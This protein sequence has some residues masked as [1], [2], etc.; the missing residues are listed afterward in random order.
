MYQA[1]EIY[2]RLARS[3]MG[4]AES[5]SAA[6]RGAD[7]AIY[8]H[9]ADPNSSPSMRPPPDQRAALQRKMSSFLEE[10]I[11]HKLTERGEAAVTLRASGDGRDAADN[12]SAEETPTKLRYAAS[13]MQGW[14]SH[15]ED[16]HCLDPPLARN[17]QQ[18]ELLKDHH[19]F[20]VFDGHGGEFASRF[21][22][23]HFVGTL[24]RQREW[25]TY[26]QLA[27]GGGSGHPS[28]LT[29]QSLAR[30]DSVTGLALL[31][32]ALTSAFLDLD[33]QLMEAQRSVRLGQLSKLETLVYS[34][35]GNVEHDVFQRGT[36][37]HNGLLNFDRTLPGRMPAQVPLE[38]SGST[39][40][41]VLVTPSHIVC[42]NAG[43]SRAFLSKR[44]NN[45]GAGTDGVLPLSFD[46]KPTNDCEVSRVER[47]GGFV[48]AG[49]VDGDL[50]VSRSFGDFGYKNCRERDDASSSGSSHG[51]SSPESRQESEPRDHRVTVHPDILVHPRDPSKDEFVVLACDGIWDRLSNRDCASL[52]RS[53]VHEEGETDV[54]L[55]CEEIIDTALERD[56]R[57]NMTCC[58]VLFPGMEADDTTAGASD[59]SFATA[60][61]AS[62]GVLRRRQDRE[63]RWGRES[64][65]AKRAHA[66][67]EERKRRNR[68]LI[69]LQRSKVPK[70]QGRR[71]RGQT[72]L[73]LSPSQEE[74]AAGAEG[75]SRGRSLAA[76]RVRSTPMARPAMQ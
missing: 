15:M 49:R 42:A 60:S 37:D 7:A 54:G 63:R 40:V 31:K 68:E 35:G 10:P 24:L 36:D 12:S 57:D 48:R 14:R 53:L 18:R 13:E 47:D 6:S 69:A 17:R 22:G 62:S 30:Q 11:T 28:P 8:W 34:L 71:A 66:R 38:R 67:L 56:S 41:V 74:K 51:S 76:R 65:P 9:G 23:E 58:V 26:L 70:S 27:S 21:C 50:A 73:Q 45:G 46:H 33:A 72:G 39:A 52:V 32:A 5:S 20:A 44:A 16:R 55:V 29:G 2:A 25:Q 64:T 3:I 4:N 61:T 19:L 43:D 1:A 75:M 59:R